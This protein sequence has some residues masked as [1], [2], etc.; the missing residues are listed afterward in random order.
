MKKLLVLV[1]ALALTLI[2]SGCAMIDNEIKDFESDTVG[3]NRVCDVI[4]E[5][6]S[7]IRT[8]E[9]TINI[10]SN[11]YGNKV[12]MYLKDAD[13]RVAIY[14]AQVICEEVDQWGD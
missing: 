11:E 2:L 7:I 6:G 13:K 9:D 10:S 3:L 1:V 14:N 5:D 4:A 12:I 8:Y